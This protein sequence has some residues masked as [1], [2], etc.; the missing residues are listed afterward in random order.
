[1][2]RT[3]PSEQHFPREACPNSTNPVRPLSR[4]HTALVCNILSSQH[5][6]PCLGKLSLPHSLWLKWNSQSQFS[7][8][9]IKGLGKW[10]PHC[11]SNSS[12]RSSTK[13][14]ER[15]SFSVYPRITSYKNIS[16][17]LLRSG[18]QGWEKAERR[19]QWGKVRFTQTNSSF[20]LEVL[21]FYC[22]QMEEI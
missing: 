10:L 21:S 1:M 11:P 19:R 5:E 22:L 3:S 7:L 6:P 4:E 12:L 2:E 15:A 18:G 16:I 17:E 13:D 14:T 8:P 20:R 9:L